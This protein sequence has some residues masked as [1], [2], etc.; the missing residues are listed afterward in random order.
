MTRAIAVLLFALCLFATEGEPLLGRIVYRT[1][2][3][4][5]DGVYAIDATGA[6]HT[7]IVGPTDAGP[8]SVVTGRQ[9]GS[10]GPQ[11]VRRGRLRPPA[12]V[13]R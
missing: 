6:N 12:R 11:H 8:P 4:V 1:D 7:R 3:V 9:A 10:R 5:S 2:E 13:H